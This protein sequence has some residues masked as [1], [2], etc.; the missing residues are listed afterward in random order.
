MAGTV[1]AACALFHESFEGFRFYTRDGSMLDHSPIVGWWWTRD[2]RFR[3]RVLT[4]LKCYLP[5]GTRDLRIERHRGGGAVDRY[6]VP[7]GTARHLHAMAATSADETTWARELE[8]S[9]V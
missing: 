9:R 4:M 2:T 6:V 8:K 3:G 5:E 7:I 1:A